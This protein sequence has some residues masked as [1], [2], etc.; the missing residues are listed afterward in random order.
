M[1]MK[2][3][4]VSGCLALVVDPRRYCVRHQE[5]EDARLKR[6]SERATQRWAQ[7]HARID[8]THIWHDPR[9]RR[10][11]AAQLKAQPNCA[12]CGNPGSSIDHLI[13]HR[14]DEALAFDPGNV[15]TLCASCHNRKTR[16]DRGQ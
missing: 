8:Y 15:Q 6:E 13:P 12:R 11:K 1:I 10:L 16:E 7:H 14:G 9:W 4:K 3:C 2:P 5:Y